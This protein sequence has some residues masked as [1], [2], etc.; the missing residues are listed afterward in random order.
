MTHSVR[1]EVANQ[2]VRQGLNPTRAINMGH[3]PVRK[4]DSVPQL[5]IA[6]AVSEVSTE[7]TPRRE[8]TDARDSGSMASDAIGTYAMVRLDDPCKSLLGP[9]PPTRTTVVRRAEGRR[10]GRKREGWMDSFLADTAHEYLIGTDSL[11]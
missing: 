11:H 7:S 9:A 3:H 4:A 5:D 1:H 8:V 2:G 6:G 10:E